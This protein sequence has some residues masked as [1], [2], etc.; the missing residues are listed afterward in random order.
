MDPV[1]SRA[2][3]GATNPVPGGT[4]DLGVALALV[5]FARYFPIRGFSFL[6]FFVCLFSFG[7]ETL[8]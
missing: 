6:F 8:V 2:A 1:A 7:C 3:G 4:V 5:A